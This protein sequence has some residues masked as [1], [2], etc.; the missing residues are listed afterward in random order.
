MSSNTVVY[1]GTRYQVPTDNHAWDVFN[2]FESYYR[3]VLQ[4]S[5][6]HTSQAEYRGIPP[7]ARSHVLINQT[8]RTITVQWEVR[9]NTTARKG[10]N[11][12]TWEISARTVTTT[13]LT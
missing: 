1:P 2:V 13:L 11:R 10:T 4:T 12:T 6:D 8:E 5:L 9:K 7:P 3:S